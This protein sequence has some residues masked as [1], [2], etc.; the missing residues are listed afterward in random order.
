MTTVIAARQVLLTGEITGNKIVGAICIFFLLGLIWTTLYL[1]LLELDPASFNN[2]NE[3]RW[4]EN[5]PKMVY[6]SFVTLTTLGYGDVTPALP[7]VQF[8]AYLEA[9]MGLFYIAVMVA[10]LVGIRITSHSMSQADEK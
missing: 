5:F 3:A 4:H 9:V 1:L 6:F 10:S 7:I 8:L 2:V